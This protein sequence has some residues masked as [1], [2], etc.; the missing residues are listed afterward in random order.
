MVRQRVRHFLRDAKLPQASPV[1]LW[2]GPATHVMCCCCAELIDAG[3]EYELAFATTVS[4]KFHPRCYVIWEEERAASGE[5]A[6]GAP[7]GR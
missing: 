1:K 4:L 6:G 2:V 5:G 7:A 3:Y